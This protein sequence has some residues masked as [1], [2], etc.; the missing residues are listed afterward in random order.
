M[1][2]IHFFKIRSLERLLENDIKRTSSKLYFKL[3]RF[4]TFF[5]PCDEA[6]PRGSLR[7]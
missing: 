6:T 4:F 3:S 2:S 1:T 5:V 7:L